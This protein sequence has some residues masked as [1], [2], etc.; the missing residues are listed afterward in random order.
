MVM[1][2]S[3][4]CKQQRLPGLQPSQLSLNGAFCQNPVGMEEMMRSDLQQ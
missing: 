1:G 3:N 2:S 4:C